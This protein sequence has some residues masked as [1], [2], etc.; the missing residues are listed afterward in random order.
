MH[1]GQSPRKVHLT[2]NLNKSPRMAR[3][4]NEFLVPKEKGWYHLEMKKLVFKGS[5]EAGPTT[6]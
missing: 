5:R 2:K 4:R 1:A 6:T 3:V